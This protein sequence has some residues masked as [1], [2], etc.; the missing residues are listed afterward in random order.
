M[1]KKVLGYGFLLAI[2]DQLLKYFVITKL[3]VTESIKVITNFFY[4]TYIKN[5]GAAF[6]MFN[7]AGII[8][9]I[10]S[11]VALIGLVKYVITD[12]N[13]TKVEAISYALVF[14]GILGNLSDRL[15]MGYVIDYLDFY[16]FG[17][18]FPVFNFADILIV[19]GFLVILINLFIKGEHHEVIKRR[20]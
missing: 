8:L 14:G 17:Y 13:I 15:F 1:Y 2:I 16:I 6:G 5:S 20:G 12:K 4:I 11:F 3:V 18:N 10:L 9:I 19:V 7:S